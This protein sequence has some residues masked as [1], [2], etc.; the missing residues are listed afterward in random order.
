MLS[1]LVSF[2]IFL[3]IVCVIAWIVAW[4][5]SNIPGAPPMASRVVW[6]VAGIIILI[7]VI[8][9]FAPMAGLH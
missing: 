9:H 2:L 7:W 6:A 3:L 4:I 1:L 5:L 8:A